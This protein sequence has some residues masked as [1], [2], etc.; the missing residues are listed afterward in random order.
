L[1]RFLDRI[2]VLGE[3]LSRPLGALGFVIVLGYP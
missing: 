1:R 2:P 3:V